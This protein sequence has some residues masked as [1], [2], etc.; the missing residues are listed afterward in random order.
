LGFF[1]L[2]LF[3][4]LPD[5]D[6]EVVPELLPKSGAFAVFREVLQHAAASWAMKK[7]LC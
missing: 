1:F 2:P 7:S 3:T 4:H 6:S 5:L